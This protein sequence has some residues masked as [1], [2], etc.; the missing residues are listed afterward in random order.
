MSQI[1]DCWRNHC[2]DLTIRCDNVL[3][4]KHSNKPVES[5]ECCCWKIRQGVQ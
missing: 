4:C 3:V 2:P 1:E 5:T